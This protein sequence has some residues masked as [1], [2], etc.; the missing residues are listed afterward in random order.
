MNL[1]ARDHNMPVIISN[2]CLLMIRA[3]LLFARHDLRTWL[4]AGSTTVC[5]TTIA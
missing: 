4:F 5:F 2:A 3:R 1:Y